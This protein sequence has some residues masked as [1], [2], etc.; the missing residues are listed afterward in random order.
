M[1]TLVDTKHAITQLPPERL[2]ELDAWYTEW[3]V[4]A[5]DEKTDQD[6]A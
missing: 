4:Q 2:H 1:A 3:R 5:W 6:S